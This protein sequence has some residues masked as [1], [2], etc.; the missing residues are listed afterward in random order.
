V[1]L[2]AFATV[3]LE[4]TASVSTRMFS[5]Q[6]SSESY[7][8]SSPTFSTPPPTFTSLPSTS[9]KL[10]MQSLE[11]MSCIPQKFGVSKHKALV[12]WA[13]AILILFLLPLAGILLFQNR[14]PLPDS[15]SKPP[16]NPVVVSNPNK[17]EEV[18]ESK[19]PKVSLRIVPI[20]D[21]VPPASY[22]SLRVILISKRGLQPVQLEDNIEPGSYQISVILPGYSCQ[23]HGKI[24]EVRPGHLFHLTL[25]LAG[26]PRKISPKIV[27]TAT[28]EWIAPLVFHIDKQPLLGNRFRPGEHDLYILFENYQ[29]IETKVWIPPGEETFQYESSLVPLREILFGLN[30]ILNKPNGTPYDLEIYVDGK[31][32][33]SVHLQY[34]ILGEDIRGRVKIASSAK[35]IFMRLGFYYTAVP[36]QQLYLVR[37]LDQLDPNFL[38]SHLSQTRE[39]SSLLQELATIGQRDK[40]KILAL[41]A[42]A[43][44]KIY[45][46]LVNNTS[47]ADIQEMEGPLWQWR[48]L[49]NANEAEEHNSFQA[50][51]NEANTISFADRVILW[52]RYLRKYPQG[53]Y[54][55][56]AQSFLEYS[57]DVA[58]YENLFR[59]SVRECFLS[60]SEKRALQHWESKLK[61]EDI[62]VVKKRIAEYV[63]QL[64]CGQ[65]LEEML[66]N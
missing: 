53:V 40:A 13:M 7:H 55:R 21:P 20:Y 56:Q 60:L 50:S 47:S 14:N 61:P 37:S 31:Q 33:P 32:L 41:P 2:D 22:P 65:S 26:I 4:V 34:Q 25:T 39:R 19:G 42:E 9:E 1:V 30:T 15:T 38:V 23:E 62:A 58:R 54:A 36:I 59:D 6:Q 46:F 63:K 27:N 35:Q 10:L 8:T 49:L 24:I 51:L 52:Q 3:E 64:G 43:Q 12:F 5:L 18:P 16:T 17:P 11:T 45:Q 57:R 28:G 29:E 48:R 66:K 44:E